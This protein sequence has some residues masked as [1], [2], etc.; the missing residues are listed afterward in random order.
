M[1]YIRLSLVTPKPARERHAAD[2]LRRLASVH[3]SQ[4]GYLAGYLL[5]ARAGSRS[6]G[7]VVIWRDAQAA[8]AAASQQHDLALRSE[9]NLVIDPASHRESAFEAHPA[10]D[11]LAAASVAASRPADTAPNFAV[12]ASETASTLADTE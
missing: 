9:L 4:P 7:R 11:L 1:P 8:N 3:R 12:A 10:P 6:I 5:A 2:L